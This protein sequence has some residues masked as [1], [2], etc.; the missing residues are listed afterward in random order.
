MPV[1]EAICQH[2]SPCPL[3]P[4]SGSLSSCHPAFHISVS[5]SLIQLSPAVDP[6][7]DFPRGLALKARFLWECLE[8]LIPGNSIFSNLI[9][10]WECLCETVVILAF[11]CQRWMV[12]REE[13]FPA[14]WICLWLGAGRLCSQLPNV[15]HPDDHNYFPAE[16]LHK[17]LCSVLRGITSH[18]K[19]PSPCLA[20]LKVQCKTGLLRNVNI[21]ED[22][23]RKPIVRAGKEIKMN[24]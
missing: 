24:K 12:K 16:F 9:S 23:A 17:Y 14:H 15:M 18:I 20:F 13:C 1:C 5:R 19:L 2:F 8:I 3:E 10:G 6:S 4:S 11:H 22:K 7:G 21:L